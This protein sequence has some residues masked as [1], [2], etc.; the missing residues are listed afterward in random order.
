MLF[1]APETGTRRHLARAQIIARSA[2]DGFQIRGI[3]EE[4][5]SRLLTRAGV[6]L[7]KGYCEAGEMSRHEER[8]G[9]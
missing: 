2:K 4:F 9:A 8:L 5:I 1:I 7:S 3:F 6:G